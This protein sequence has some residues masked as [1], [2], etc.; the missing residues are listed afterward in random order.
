VSTRFPQLPVLGHR[1][2]KRLENN[3]DKIVTLEKAYAILEAQWLDG[4]LDDRQYDV[5]RKE[6]KAGAERRA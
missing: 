2:K 6:F 3:L 5:L 1:P 4:L